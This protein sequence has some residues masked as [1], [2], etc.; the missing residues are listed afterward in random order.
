MNRRLLGLLAVALLLVAGVM[1]ISA[2]IVGVGA[3]VEANADGSFLRPY[4]EMGRYVVV[5]NQRVL[6]VYDDANDLIYSYEF[7]PE[8]GSEVFSDVAH[9]FFLDRSGRLLTVT[10]NG[11]ARI[12][13]VYTGDVL[14]D[15]ALPYRYM[16]I[17]DAPTG[18]GTYFYIPNSCRVVRLSVDG[19]AVTTP[20]MC[21]DVFDSV[22]FGRLATG[23]GDYLYLIFGGYQSGRLYVFAYDIS[24]GVYTTLA[25]DPP[26]EEDKFVAA[27]ESAMA[28]AD[29]QGNLIVAPAL[30]RREKRYIYHFRFDGSSLQVVNVIPTN[31]I[32]IGDGGFY[33]A[34][35][36]GNVLFIDSHGNIT[37]SDVPP[38]YLTTGFFLN[39]MAYLDGRLYLELFD[40]TGKSNK[41][42][43]FEPTESGYGK[44]VGYMSDSD[45]YFNYSVPNVVYGATDGNVFCFRYGKLPYVHCTPIDY[46]PWLKVSPDTYRVALEEQ[47]VVL[48][49]ADV[50]VPAYT[51][52]LPAPAP[53]PEE[54]VPVSKP[55]WTEYEVVVKPKAGGA[56]S[57]TGVPALDVGIVVVLLF[58]LGYIIWRR[59]R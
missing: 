23:A 50:N 11:R 41:V 26:S 20:Y 9:T 10:Y 7:V 46:F 5:L 25:I 14:V 47:G 21:G 39:Q 51:P 4:I 37:P 35:E 6:A 44:L 32:L 55:Y 52:P 24:S 58:V 17:S 33:F 45:Q 30:F 15:Y 34:D 31:G 40:F 59:T 2:E 1:L 22:F 38:Q 27:L 3:D 48:F 29:D 13:D 49:S 57:I 36:N 19:E 42:Y 43:V 54:N 56:L 16:S 12:Y 53:A 18:D 8:S 28:F